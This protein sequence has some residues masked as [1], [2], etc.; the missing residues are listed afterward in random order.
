M[1]LVNGQYV[2]DIPWHTPQPGATGLS[3]SVEPPETTTDSS[4]LS[5]DTAAVPTVPSTSTTDSPGVFEDRNARDGVGQTNGPS[6]KRVRSDDT[7][8]PQ[9]HNDDIWA[10][11]VRVWT[12]ITEGCERIISSS[13]MTRQRKLEMLDKAATMVEEKRFFGATFPCMFPKA[14]VRAKGKLLSRTSMQRNWVVRNFLRLRSLAAREC[15]ERMKRP[16]P[17]HQRPPVS[18][19]TAREKRSPMVVPVVI[20]LFRRAARAIRYLPGALDKLPSRLEREIL[21]RAQAVKNMH[22]VPLKCCVSSRMGQP[23]PP[24][25]CCCCCCCCR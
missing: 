2:Y 14:K 11:G 24:C 8:K 6:A 23:F 17:V 20:Q 4:L 22:S 7:L 9:S 3:G 13:N 19:P 25:C 18:R 5:N 1:S 16:L 10:K 21:R 12:N 15:L